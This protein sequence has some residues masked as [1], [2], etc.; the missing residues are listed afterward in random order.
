MWSCQAAAALRYLVYGGQD[1][2]ASAG[3]VPWAVPRC[4]RSD[5][6]NSQQEKPLDAPQCPCGLWRFAQ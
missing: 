1:E 4:Q 5:Q 6:R 2:S 3:L